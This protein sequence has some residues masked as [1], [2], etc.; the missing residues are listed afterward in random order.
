MGNK[1]AI[2]ILLEV[3]ND[4]E[5][6]QEMSVETMKMLCEQVKDF[7]KEQITEAYRSGVADERE[8]TEETNTLRLLGK[9]YA[10]TYEH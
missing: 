10:Q 8:D 3:L 1:T 6:I 9:Y 4:L 5:P 2:T 7:E